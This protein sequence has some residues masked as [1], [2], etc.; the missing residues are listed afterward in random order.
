[1]SWSNKFIKYF[2]FPSA[3]IF[4]GIFI[5]S[6]VFDG[7]KS[8][9][10]VNASAQNSIVTAPQNEINKIKDDI[11]EKIGYFIK[12]LSR[13][14]KET[15]EAYLVGDLDTGEIIAEKNKDSIFPIASVSKLMTSVVTLESLNGDDTATVSKSALRAYGKSG[16]LRAG[17]KFKVSDLLYPLLLESSNDTGEV[18]AEHM[19]R[20]D[21]LKAM[22][23]KAYDLGMKNTTY[24]DPTGLTPKNASTVSDLFKLAVYI[25]KNENQIFEITRKDNYTLGSHFWHN[26]NNLIHQ[27]GYLGGKS[28]YIDEAKK[29]GV[30]LFN[31]PL[32]EDKSKSRNVAIIVLRSDDRFRDTTSLVSYLKGNFYYGL[33]SQASAYTAIENTI[34]SDVKDY[35][36]L[37][38]VGDIMLDR[39]VKQSVVKNLGGDY[40]LM[41][42]DVPQIKDADIAFANLEGPVSDQGTDLNNLYSFRMDPKV[43]DA[44]KDAGF[45][46]L[47]VA[48][49]HIGDW[50]R[51]AFADSIARLKEKDL[52]PIG[53]DINYAEATKPKIIEKNGL[54]IGYIG[55]TDVGP[56]NMEAGNP[57]AGGPG[58]LLASDPNF[59]SIVQKA[60]EQVDALVVSF[61]FGEEY[62]DT[63][64]R[65]KQLAHLA[66][67]SGAKIVVGTH[68]HVAQGVEEYE[69]GL[70]M[71]SLGNFIFDQAFSKDTMQGLMVEVKID[72]NLN[73]N[74]KK[75]LVKLDPTFKP[76]E[77]IELRK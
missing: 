21:F 59:E 14:P 49:N 4:T 52:L 22:N 62:K 46:A 41:F 1:M 71:Y 5:T 9:F 67:D 74:Y 23:A 58:I 32:S 42:K 57:P 66:I 17:E 36:N 61:H 38:F 10:I 44:L 77:V 55:F 28:G 50:G 45:D 27:K 7:I 12:D 2:I 48:N 26:N 24:E 25:N 33:A 68:P 11:A 13:E 69:G 29:T 19:G 16:N 35:V 73:L 31:I 37:S 70:I 30:A 8:H 63:T 65:Q 43:L 39:G 34:E 53:G 64:E 47:S 54:K 15:A 40:S 76:S 18:L 56:D 75:E 51:S 6:V 3:A 60:S 72:K 20:P